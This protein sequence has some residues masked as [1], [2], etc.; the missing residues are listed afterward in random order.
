MN[1]STILS[2]SC[3]VKARR[4]RSIALLALITSALAGSLRT[5]CAQYTPALQVSARSSTSTSTDSTRGYSFD[6]TN[7]M[8]VVVTA[9]SVYDTFGDGLSDSHEV[10]LWDSSGAVLASTAIPAGAS[11]PLDSSGFFRYEQITPMTLAPGA[12]YVVGALFLSGTLD[13]Q[14]FNFSTISPAPGLHY[15]QARFINNGVA[16]LTFPTSTFGFSGLV[17]GSFDIAIVP[18]PLASV[19]LGLGFA[20]VHAHRRRTSG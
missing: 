10:G 19:L 15:D 8:G 16:S 9:L 7:P 17:G 11:A 1:T 5:V 3:H 20:V 2:R 4:T 6:V 18:E 13:N 14:A 12:N